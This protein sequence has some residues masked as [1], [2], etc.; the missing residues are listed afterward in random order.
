MSGIILLFAGA[1]AFFANFIVGN[2]ALHYQL[3]NFARKSSALYATAC[4][5]YFFVLCRASRQP[6]RDSTDI[7]AKYAI[8]VGLLCSLVGFITP[9]FIQWFIQELLQIDDRIAK[10]LS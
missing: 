9:F 2:V 1:T 7:L 6:R 10:M 4:I 5:I 8:F 3:T